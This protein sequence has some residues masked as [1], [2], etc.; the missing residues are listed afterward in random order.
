MI[1]HDQIES[2]GT[3]FASLKEGGIVRYL[4][5][6]LIVLILATRPA[7][8]SPDQPGMFA[9]KNVGVLPMDRERVLAGQTVIVERGVIAR[10]SAAAD[11]RIPEGATIIDGTGRF[12]IPGLIDAH[13]H[14]SFFTEE[15]QRT[16]LTIFVLT[17]VTT[18]VNL[19][20]TPQVLELR[21]AVANGDVFG[22]TLYT[23]GPY[24]S[25]GSWPPRT[26]ADIG[27]RATAIAL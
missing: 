5:P 25:S 9:I 17:G 10:L 24:I 3:R 7:S 21:S 26:P 6:L 19:K 12:L 23:V 4:I 2:A 20:G 15:Q 22:P 16:I 8:A 18:V 1:P 14:L 11:V 27:L 13:V